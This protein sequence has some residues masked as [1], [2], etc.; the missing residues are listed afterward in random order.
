M[1]KRERE[2]ASRTAEKEMYKK[3]FTKDIWLVIRCESLSCEPSRI[4]ED[5]R[6]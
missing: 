4:L 6:A 5:I 2:R 3:C 1:S